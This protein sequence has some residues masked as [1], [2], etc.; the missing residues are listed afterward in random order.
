MATP[1]RYQ[2]MRVREPT[3]GLAIQMSLS[4]EDDYVC[5]DVMIIISE[6]SYR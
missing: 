2:Y 3:H 5:I 6:A 4:S 1:G